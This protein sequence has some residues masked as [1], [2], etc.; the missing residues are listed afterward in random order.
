[1]E[2]LRFRLGRRKYVVYKLECSVCGQTFSS[3][4]TGKRVTCGQR[5]CQKMRPYIKKTNRKRPEWDRHTSRI[6]LMELE[7]L[8]RLSSSLL[9]P[10]KSPSYSQARKKREKYNTK[11]TQKQLE[12]IAGI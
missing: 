4:G 6:M 3:Y 2:V 5:D 10:S 9:P 7:R 8:A 11:I 1:M 12:S